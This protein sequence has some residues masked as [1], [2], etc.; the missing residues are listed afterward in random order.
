MKR[1]QYF[2]V[3]IILAASASA[4]D[5]NVVT[6]R[7]NYAP[8][9]TFQAEVIFN[10]DPAVDLT[11][12]NF[13]LY[14]DG[15]IATLNFVEKL[16]SRHYF[17]YFDIPNTEDGEYHFKLKNV[18]Y[19]E[20]EIL[21]TFGKQKPFNVNSINDGFDYLISSQNPDGSFGTAGKTALAGL[22]LKNAY[23]EM[24]NNAVSYLTANQDPTGCYPNGNCKVIDSSLAL[25]ALK[26]FNE[27]YIK[28]R[29]WLKDAGNNYEI[30]SWNLKINGNGVC[31]Y[32]NENYTISGQLDIEVSSSNITIECDS[33][34]NFILRH[35]YLGND[36]NIYEYFGSEFSYGIE[37]SGCYGVGFKDKC[38][39]ISTL[40][41]SWGLQKVGEFYPEDYLINNRLENRTLDHALGYII[42]GDDYSRDWLLNNQIG[43]YWS[44]NSASIS[45]TPDYYISAL[46]SYA[47][48]DEIVFA[49]SKNYL[50]DKTEND[51]LSSSM[52]L[53]L[54]F[55]DQTIQDSVSVS[56]GI[57]NNK[58]IF[59]LVLTNHEN[60][61]SVNIEA[62]N[63]TGLPSEIELG[64]S[65]EFEVNIPENTESFEINIEYSNKSYTIP[66]ILEVI[67]EGTVLLPPPRD[68]LKFILDKDIINLTANRRD[69][70]F[71]EISFTNSW[72][73][74]I[75]NVSIILT[76]NL[77]EII[78]LK[79]DRF[80]L[81][82]SG[83]TISTE[84][85]INSERDAGL[86]F[87]QGFIVLKSAK[88]VDSVPMI[89]N[90]EEG[91]TAA[92]E[93]AT[94]AMDVEAENEETIEE[95]VSTTSSQEEE[96]GSLWWLW[97]LIILIIGVIAF[98]FFRRKKV[99]TE[100]L[101]DYIKK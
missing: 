4:F 61:V 89:L 94:D 62:P 19:I 93:G 6:Y 98:L 75:G 47:L 81:I 28:T 78:E 34:F 40:Y 77:N 101:G 87:Y 17:V 71:D 92:D 37:D 12:T 27:N 50:S 69:V 70:L 84:L 25:I 99:I 100:D 66:V 63:F 76:G 57:V 42:H 22:A 31:S 36:Y 68:A 54:L 39:Y 18:K 10:E 95:T 52:I 55:N 65:S 14:R 58:N 32:E 3:F 90:F 83:D 26:E 48:K 44:Y 11:S 45:Q 38:D 13:E 49:G 73:F 79:E 29:N 91:E 59:E 64:G 8:L 67:E 46:A 5:A 72:D 35:S 41:A 9:E 15:S 97:L 20:G 1:L 24:A 2:F 21:K 88:T 51:M 60:P 53:Y 82:G 56:P 96:K 86:N 33:E 85:T 23:N 80:D 30:G 7:D 43:S 16:N 74:N